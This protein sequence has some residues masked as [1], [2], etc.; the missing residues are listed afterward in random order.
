VSWEAWGSG[1]DPP[2]ECDR[3][4]EPCP[5]GRALRSI[6][7]ERLCRACMT[8]EEEDAA[9]LGDDFTIGLGRDGGE[10]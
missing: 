4:G 2:P 7:G 6:T 1:D 5:D 3:C 8:E 9:E 10:Q